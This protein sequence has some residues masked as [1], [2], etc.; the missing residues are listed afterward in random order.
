MLLD[1]PPLSLQVD[2]VREEGRQEASLDASGK[3]KRSLLLRLR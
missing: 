3:V 2:W 1:P